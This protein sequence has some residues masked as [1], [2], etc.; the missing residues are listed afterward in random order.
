MGRKRTDQA[1]GLRAST[2]FGNA[3]VQRFGDVSLSFADRHGFTPVQQAI[4]AN[5]VR[6]FLLFLDR[7]ADFGAG[8]RNGGCALHAALRGHLMPCCAL[9]HLCPG[10]LNTAA[11]NGQTPLHHAILSRN[12]EVASFFVS[13][14]G[15][16]RRWRTATGAR[17]CT[18]LRNA[19]LRRSFD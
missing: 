11:I 4:I 8:W 9:L 16:A 10:R 13:R 7:G 17:R 14:R 5:N 3:L 6:I 12:D 1:V 19:G 2:T 15:S 18:W